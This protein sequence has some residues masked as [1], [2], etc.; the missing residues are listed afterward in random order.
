MDVKAYIRIY[1]H[2]GLV[3]NFRFHFH[4]CN[5]NYDMSIGQ[6]IMHSPG[7]NLLFDMAEISWENSKVHMQPPEVLQGDWIET[8]EQKLLFAHDPDTMN[9]ERIKGIIESKYFQVDLNNC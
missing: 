8:L 7:I 3:E 9:A 5:S 6:D 2:H 4:G 1:L